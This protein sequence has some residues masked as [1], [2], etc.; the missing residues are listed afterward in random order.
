MLRLKKCLIV[1][2]AF[3]ALLLLLAGCTAKVSEKTEN[4]GETENKTLA[5]GLAQFPGNLDPADQYNGWYVV[6]FGVGETL[7][8]I[9]KDMKIEPWLAE[10]WKKVDDLTWQIKI[11]DNVIFHNGTKVTGEAVKASLE[12]TVAMNKR[13]SQLL[14]IASIEVNGNEITVKNNHPNPSFIPA[15]ADPFAVI[16]DVD[17]A[18]TMG[19]E[20]AEKP[21]ATGPFKIKGYAKD[22]EVVVEKNDN[23]WGSKPKLDEVVFKFI[24]DSNTRVMALQAG[25]IQVADNIPAESVEAIIKTGAYQILSGSSLRTHM[26][27]FNVT[28][29][30]LDDVNVRKAINMA[31]NREDLAN[32]VMKESAIPAVG[33]FPL[34][35]PFGGNELEGYA[36]QPEEAKKLLDAAGWKPGSDGVRRKNDRKLEFSVLC[37]KNRPELPVLLEAIQA[38]LKEIGVKINIIN[39]ENIG[40]ALKKDFDATIYSLNTAPYGD[41]QYF[42]E[43]VFKTGA[44][45]NFGKYSNPRLDLL[46]DKLKTTFNVQERNT[47]A[48]EAQQ[49]VLNDAAFAFLVYPK[50]L[51]AM[52]NKVEG[53]ELSPS[54]F[55]MLNPDVTV[56]P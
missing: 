33:P 50:S 41:P 4:K 18:R 20:F 13:A 40:E 48:K 44:A 21:V 12:R 30:G 54:E 24:P 10:T 14:D 36:Y 6:K 26:L 43:T 5:V 3:C 23:Y 8:K 9:G 16:V 51:L 46:T 55:Y 11:R 17:A 25:E 22:V 39:V 2:V 15:L 37:Y 42:L 31:I 27:I 52:S 1:L 29:P 49:I 47:I 38:E 34:V 28:K 19:E 7:V 56:R 53:I 32:K 35:L 45:S